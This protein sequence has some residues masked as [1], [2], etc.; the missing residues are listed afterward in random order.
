MINFFLCLE[1]LREQVPVGHPAKS[2]IAGLEALLS[3]SLSLSL[4]H[5]F[6]TRIRICKQTSFGISIAKLT[7]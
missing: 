6:T 1:P 7:L 3:L 4:S 2:E 5:K